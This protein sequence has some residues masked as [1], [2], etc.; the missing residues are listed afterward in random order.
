MAKKINKKGQPLFRDMKYCVRCCIPETEEGHQRD[1]MGICRACQSSEQ[2][3]HIDW[4][5]RENNLRRILE[6]SK[7]KANNNYDCLL[8]ISGGKD[9]MFQAHVLINV[10]KMKP[11][12]VTF[13][14]NWFSETGWYNLMNLLETFNIDHIMYTP[15]RDLVNR[16][17][18][19]SLKTIGD[20]CWHCHSGCGAFPLQVAVKF[21]I[22]LIVYGESV[23]ESQGRASYYDPIKYDRE[24]FTKI[25][26]K[27]TPDQM[28][29]DYITPKDVQPFQLPSEQE[30]EEVGVTG[31]HL[32]DYIFWDDERQTEFV[33]DEYGWRETEME[34]SY[35]RYKSAEC[36]MPG[37][38]DFTCYLKRGYGRATAQACVD[39]RNGLLTREEGFRLISQIDPIRPEALDYFLRITNMS[40]DEFYKTME[41]QRMPQIKGVGIPILPKERSNEE[42]ILPFTQQLIERLKSKELSHYDT[43]RQISIKIKKRD[44]LSADIFTQYSV[45]QILERYIDRT[46]T[47]ADVAEACISRI[48]EI[49][50]ILHAF[51]AFN[52]ELLLKEARKNEQRILSGKPIRLLEGIPVGIKDIFNTRD[53][54]TEMGSPLWKGFSPG[55]DARVVFNVKRAG[56]LVAGKTD[57]A[58]FAVHALGKSLNPHDLSRNPGTSSSGSAVAVATGMVPVALGS[59]TAGSIIRPASY[60]GVYGFKPSFGLIPRTGTLKT[61]DSLDTLGFFTAYF[62]DLETVFNVLRVHG[63]DYPIS[64]NILTDKQRQNKPDNLPWRIAL[65]PTSDWDFIHPYAE[66]SFFNWIDSIK[67]DKDIEVVEVKLPDPMRR[68]YE[69]HATIYDSTLAYYF[70]DEAKRKDLVSPIMYEL[71]EH[72]RSITKEQYQKALNDQEE[73]IVIMD[74]LMSAFDAG[75]CLSTVGEAPFREE[76]ER[77]DQAL[78]WTLCHLP[79][80]SAPVFVSPGGLPFGAQ[81]FGRKYNDFLLLKFAAYFRSRDYIPEKM[82]PQVKL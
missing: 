37:M 7:A 22:P 62:E 42:R 68:C 43:G 5:E 63:R 27:K 4:N 69:I 78:M 67:K 1:N 82:H 25:S 58:E 10:Y 34:N 74:R 24:Y 46:M 20:T 38:H 29:C 44:Q 39:V 23:A 40:E 8:P 76:I 45:K 64:N 18:K 81:I 61:T 16:M 70:K 14:H 59:Q 56:G 75:L 54:P 53:F 9:S 12:A 51:H 2:K 80:I 32:G 15:N 3:M 17:A 13:N 65:F 36:V 33:R 66:K 72:G 79:A 73:L 57:T 50:P 11:L 77:K 21:K 30:C 71:I 6:E 52:P 55:N 28:I 19:R 35:K 47:P 48:H 26:A 41:R 31:I 49:D 60:C